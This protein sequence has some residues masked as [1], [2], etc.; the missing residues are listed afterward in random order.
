[1]CVF[2]NVSIIYNHHLLL[3]CPFFKLTLLLL[4]WNHWE[5]G[6]VA[7]HAWLTR[8][9][10]FAKFWGKHFILFIIILLT[11]MFWALLHLYILLKNWP[12]END[13]ITFLMMLT[14]FRIPIWINYFNV[15]ISHNCTDFR[16]HRT[17]ESYTFSSH[18]P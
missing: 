5:G 1:M 6:G 14:P 11:S 8:Y 2:C 13:I 7:L 3:K 9:F 12:N 18:F 4:N 17:K 16:Q 15:S 10:H